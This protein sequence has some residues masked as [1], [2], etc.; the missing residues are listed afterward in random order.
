MTPSNRRT[1]ISV[2]LS[3]L[4]PGCGHVHEGRVLEGLAFAGGTVAV[5]MLGTVAVLASP[6]LARVALFGATGGWAAVWIA[7]AVSAASLTPSRAASEISP[8]EDH[9][10]ALQPATR[11]YF[12]VLLA[13]LTAASVGMWALAVR[14]RVA[15]VFRVPSRSMMPAIAPG[16]R[17]IVDK[18]AYRTG[19]VRR[20]DIVVFVNPN[21]RQQTYVKRVV[22]LPGD[23]VELRGDDVLVNGIALPH[24]PSGQE[25]DGAHMLRETNDG[26][27][28][29]IR[30]AAWRQDGDTAA[31]GPT[32]VPNGACF[33][34]GDDRRRSVDSR[35]VGPIPLA[36]IVGRVAR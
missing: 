25:A 8:D 20:G 32:R 34:L 33:V 23:V 3:L 18:T 26:V 5:G 7:A 1:T 12:K 6:G 30:I 16:D 28:Y 17:V 19:P 9:A 15:E 24:E 11:A 35:D 27:H 21:E 4:A 36:D 14:E 2:F 22:A 31:L 10:R 29:L 13:V